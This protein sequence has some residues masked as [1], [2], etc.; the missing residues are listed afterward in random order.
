MKKQFLEKLVDSYLHKIRETI[1]E[2]DTYEIPV[3]FYQ[4]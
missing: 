4:G 2:S 3:L 1:D